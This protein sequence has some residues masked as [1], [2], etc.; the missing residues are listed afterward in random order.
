MAAR[1]KTLGELQEQLNTF[2]DYYNT[3][4]PHCSLDRETP[5]EA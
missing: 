4:R 1:T 3:I 5:T 2:T